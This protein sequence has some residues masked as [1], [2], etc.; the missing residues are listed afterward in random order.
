MGKG[1]PVKVGEKFLKTYISKAVPEKRYFDDMGLIYIRHGQPNNFVFDVSDTVQYQNMS[2]HYYPRYNRSELA[3]HFTKYKGTTGWVIESMPFSVNYREEINPLYWR[4]QP[5]I[6]SKYF[7]GVN[8]K[9]EER[10]R[11][12]NDIIDVADKLSKMNVKFVEIG[13]KT[14][15]TEYKYDKK[16]LEFPFDFLTFKGKNGKTSVELYYGIE[17]KKVELETGKQGNTMNLSRFVGIYDWNWNECLRI[18]KDDRIPVNLTPEQWK[19]SSA[20]D[21]EQFEVSPGIYNYEFHLQ[22]NVSDK[23][24]VYKDSLAVDDY[25][26]DNL[27]LSDV[28]LSTPIDTANK[29]LPFKKGNLSYDPRMFSDFK[30]DAVIGIYSE[31]YNLN[32]DS[33]NNTHYEVTLTFQPFGTDKESGKN[34]ATRFT[35][36]LF[37]KREEIISST[38]KYSGSSRDEVLYFNLKPESEKSGKFELIISVRDLNSN[39]QVSKKVIISLI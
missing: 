29:N 2:W 7:G 27:M 26:R 30:K 34:I 21:M 39:K 4:L 36:R 14:E 5:L 13:V 12:F 16:P 35:Q 6:E 28:I 22:D 19:N 23:L 38:Y 10:I 37:G 20:T 25:W 31:L 15:T 32:F 1:I 9:L 11:G 17:G 24:G 18:N 3:F 8:E 33:K